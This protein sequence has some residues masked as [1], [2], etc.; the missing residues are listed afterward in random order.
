MRTILISRG[1]EIVVAYLKYSP[2][3]H[4]EECGEI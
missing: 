1:K 3:V 4:W 2:D